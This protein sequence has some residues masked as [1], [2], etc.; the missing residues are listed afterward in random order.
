[1]V[2][3]V[4]DRR[5]TLLMVCDVQER[6]REGT[7]GFDHM[8]Q[9]ISKLIRAAK[10]LGM[11]TLLTEQNGSGPTAHE[12]KS[13]IN[14]P[15]HIGTFGKDGFSMITDETED[16]VFKYDNFLLVGIEAHVCILQTAL[17][18][19]DIPKNRKRVYVLADAISACHELEIPLAFDR[20]RDEGAVV[21]TSEAIL[22]QLM[23]DG[24]SGDDTPI[25]DL[26]KAERKNTAKAL[27]TLLPHPSQTA[28]IRKG[29]I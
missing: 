12:V 27:E 11:A 23:G 8:A 28:P 21:T 4:V 25:S 18:L 20:M 13:V 7:H 26:I 2:H 6:F 17:D 16:I 14:G 15:Q 5:R 22:F 3:K 19:L 29:G 10:F 9:S 24:T 1:M